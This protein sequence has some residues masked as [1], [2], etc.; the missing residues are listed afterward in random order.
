MLIEDRQPKTPENLALSGLGTEFLKAQRALGALRLLAPGDI[1]IGRMWA[2]RS[3]RFSAELGGS[4]ILVASTAL[5]SGGGADYF[6]TDEVACAVPEMY[7]ALRDLEESNYAATPGNLALALRSFMASYDRWPAG[8]ES[9]LVDAITA[10]EAV[11]GAKSEIAFKLAFRLSAVLASDDAERVEIFNQ[12][13]AYYDARSRIVHGDPLKEKHQALVDDV[14][15]L[16]ELLRRLLRGLLHLAKTPDQSFDKNFFSSE[17][18]A[19]LLDETA[20]SALRRSMGLEQS[21]EPE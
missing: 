4:T 21:G 17:L 15:P 12:V 19:A 14:E 7:R 11:L 16:R 2:T 9:R 10:T 3:G 5:A 18:D 1:A 20:R 6:L 8:G 13:K